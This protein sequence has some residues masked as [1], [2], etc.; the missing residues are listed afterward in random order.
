MPLK[1]LGGDVPSDLQK[2]IFAATQKAFQSSLKLQEIPKA[3]K[4]RL[5]GLHGTGWVVVIGRDVYTSLRYLKETHCVL[6]FSRPS[7]PD[8]TVMVCKCADDVSPKPSQAAVVALQEALSKAAALPR[9]HA[10]FQ[11]HLLVV[12]YVTFLLRASTRLPTVELE[13]SS[14]DVAV[15]AFVTDSLREHLKT[16]TDSLSIVQAVKVPP[17]RLLVLPP[18]VIRLPCCSLPCGPNMGLLGMC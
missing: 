10:S 13:F 3:I 1:L 15:Q 18:S 17:P 2:D 9:R 5:E 12:R 14:M 11:F 6:S 4:D 8:V 16:Y 7:R